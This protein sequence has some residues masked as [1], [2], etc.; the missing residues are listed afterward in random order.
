MGKGFTMEER[1]RIERTKYS[2]MDII[3]VC[4]TEEKYYIKVENISPL[5]MGITM[6]A[7]SPDIIGKEVIIVAECMVMFAVVRRMIPCEDGSIEVGV[8]AKPYTRDMLNC[9]YEGVI[10]EQIE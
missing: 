10:R 5:G 8:E 4:D 1:R 3:I 9:L 2:A 7:G 6:P